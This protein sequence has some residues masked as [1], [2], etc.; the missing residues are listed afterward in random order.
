MLSIVR[1][2]DERRVQTDG[3][4]AFLWTAAVAAAV[5]LVTVWSKR[6]AVCVAHVETQTESVDMISKVWVRRRQV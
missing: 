3:W 1:C 6:N 5:V 2:D 4:I